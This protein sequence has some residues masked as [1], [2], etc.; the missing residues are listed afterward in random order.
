VGTP[1]RRLRARA[2]HV[3][4]DECEGGENFFAAKDVVNRLNR[5]IPELGYKGSLV[6]FGPGCMLDKGSP[7]IG[8]GPA[9]YRTAD[10]ADALDSVK[11]AGGGTPL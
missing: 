1:R 7:R 5:T 4:V 8:Y 9:T 10:L 2:R 6:T 11:C 3:R